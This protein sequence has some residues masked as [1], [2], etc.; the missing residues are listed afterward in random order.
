MV[1]T[2]PPAPYNT[3]LFICQN[4]NTSQRRQNII[5]P[6]LETEKL[7]YGEM[8]PLTRNHSAEAVAEPREETRVPMQLSIV[9]LLTL[10]TAP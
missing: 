6:G 1:I 8:K 3:A 10:R 7:K 4:Q 5:I 2:P 9:R